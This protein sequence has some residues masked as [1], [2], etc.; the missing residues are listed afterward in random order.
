MPQMVL[1][2]EL[3]GPTESLSNVRFAKF[4]KRCDILRPPQGLYAELEPD[5]A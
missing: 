1:P 2:A 5:K 3:V 4:C